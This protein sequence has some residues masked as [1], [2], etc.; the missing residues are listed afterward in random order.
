MGGQIHEDE[1]PVFMLK[2]DSIEGLVLG[3]MTTYL[4]T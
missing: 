4:S 2:S 3:E 1:L